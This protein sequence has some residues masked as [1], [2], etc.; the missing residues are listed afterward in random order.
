MEDRTLFKL[1]PPPPKISLETVFSKFFYFGKGL[2]AYILFV[3]SESRLSSDNCIFIVFLENVFHLV[4]TL[5]RWRRLFTID[6]LSRNP[7]TIL[8]YIYCIT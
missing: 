4:Y 3:I 2:N 7:F 5:S 8:P 6:L 1:N